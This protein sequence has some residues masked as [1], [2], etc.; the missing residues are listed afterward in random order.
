MASYAGIRASMGA[1]VIRVA[2]HGS[3]IRRGVGRRLQPRFRQV[4]EI[5]DKRLRARPPAIEVGAVTTGVL[6]EGS[7][8]KDMT[9]A[10]VPEMLPVMIC[11]GVPS[12]GGG[13]R[14]P[15]KVP[16]TLLTVKLKPVSEPA[17][18]VAVAPVGPIMD[19]GVVSSKV[20]CT[21]VC[22]TTV[23]LAAGAPEL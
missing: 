17:S 6:N 7:I 23:P 19:S 20:V 13:G 21:V 8:V 2:G 18:M 3:A 10:F 9:S 5:G 16:T 22:E 11:P 1:S 14:G 12:G 15:M 4:L